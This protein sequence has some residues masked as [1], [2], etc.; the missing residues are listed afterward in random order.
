MLSSLRNTQGFRGHLQSSQSPCLTRELIIFRKD[1]ENPSLL[2]VSQRHFSALKTCYCRT[3]LLRE[4]AYD[5][6]HLDYNK[7]CLFP[8]F[9]SYTFFF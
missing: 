9:I 3:S 4:R 5:K 2:Y 1:K 7:I 6:G 8:K